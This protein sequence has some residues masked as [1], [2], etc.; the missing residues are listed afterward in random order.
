MRRLSSCRRLAASLPPPPARRISSRRRSATS[1]PPSPARRLPHSSGDEFYSLDG[2]Q[3]LERWRAASVPPSS[4]VE[5]RLGLDLATRMG[6][7]SPPSYRGR[8]GASPPSPS[9]H[10][11][12]RLAPFGPVALYWPWSSP[13]GPGATTQARRR[14]PEERARQQAQRRQS[15][16]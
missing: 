12:R 15:S 13:T 9:C 7:A 16:A 3:E 2:R 4:D 8:S 10:R 1:L 5:I 11:R 6:G 14:A